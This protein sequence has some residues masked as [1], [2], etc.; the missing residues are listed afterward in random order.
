MNR[1]RFVRSGSLSVLLAGCTG[2]LETKDDTGT[3]DT[4][5][6]DSGDTG[7]VACPSLDG[8]LEGLLAFVGESS[9][10]VGYYDD[11]GLDGRYA[12]DLE[13]LD[14]VDPTPPVFFVRT[15]FPDTIDPDALWTIDVD[16]VHWPLDTLP[17][18]TD[19][20][21][22]LLECSGNSG[23][24]NFGLISAGQWSGVR[25]LD[26]IEVPDGKRVLIEGYDDHTAT[27]TH[28]TEGCS[29]VFTE[30]DLAEAFLATGLNG[31]ELPEHNGWPVR[32]VIPGWFGCCCIKWVVRIAFVDDAVDATS[33]MKEFASRTHQNGVPDKARDYKPARMQHAAMPIRVER[34]ST[35]EG[36]VH[37]VVGIA[38]GGETPTDRLQIRF[39]DGD[40][41]D[42]DICPEMTQNG[43]WTLWSHSWR[44]EPGTYTLRMRVD[45][46]VPQVRLDSAFYERTVTVEA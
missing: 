4:D 24:R 8:T 13:A 45:D 11:E 42:V 46:A 27:S 32:L 38:W 37:R 23:S 2:T 12:I 22:V 36:T 16:G 34:W 9:V 19:Q 21:P 40:W 18:A 20:G 14:E 10:A 25:L 3:L 31:E 6:G 17:Q 43:T 26:W 7:E 33:Q 41:E 30:D 1:R 39:G 28:S 15:M 44:P 35:D 5:T 29:W